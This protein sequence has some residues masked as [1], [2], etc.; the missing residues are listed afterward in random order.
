MDGIKK[1]LDAYE[2][3]KILDIGSG[4]G[5]FIQLL[6]SVYHDYQEIIGIDI[7]DYILEMDEDA[8]KNNPKIKWMDKDVLDT[9]FPKQSFEV[10]SLSNT[11]HHIS[12]LKSLFDKMERLLKPG[13]ILIV[14]ELFASNDLTS[15]QLSHKILHSF[16]AKI[17]KEMNMLHSQ[18][19]SKE[20]IIEAIKKYASLPIEEHWVLETKPY[21]GHVNV[22]YLWG[23]VDQL[24]ESVKGSSKYQ[25]YLVEAKEIKAY[26]KENG[27]SLQKQV[28]VILKKAVS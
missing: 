5:D 8:F 17:L 9:I 6:D 1:Y 24:L 2:H 19:S 14:T 13:G 16:S 25:A 4:K 21:E 26:L 20:N 18:I 7:V 11:L 28:C 10:I 12:D 27:L 23:L 15:K 22:E 3:P